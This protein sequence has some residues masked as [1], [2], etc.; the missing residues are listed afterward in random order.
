MAG[1]GQACRDRA[2]DL[3][4]SSLDSEDL[5]RTGRVCS[6]DLRDAGGTIERLPEA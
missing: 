3:H 5:R 4:R 2:E 1:G 6:L